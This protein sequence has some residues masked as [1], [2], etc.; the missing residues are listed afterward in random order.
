MGSLEDISPAN[1]KKLI[2]ILCNEG[3]SEIDIL[4]GE[5]TLHPAISNFVE[6][7]YRNN[8]VTSLS[9]NGYDTN[10]LTAWSSRYEKSRVNIGV[11]LYPENRSH[12]LRRYIQACQPV[13]KSVAA[14]GAFV[15][16][17]GAYY[18]RT[19]EL[20]YSVIYMDVLAD[21]D[22]PRSLPF[23][24]FYR[25]LR[26][27]QAIFQ[28]LEGVYCSGFV[29]DVMRNPALGHTRCPA[30]TTKLSVLPDGCVYPCYLLFPYRQFFLGNIFSDDFDTIW[31]NRIL[32]FFRDFRGNQCARRDCT[33]FDD[34]HGGCPAISLSIFGD[35]SRGDPRCT[36]MQK[37]TGSKEER[38]NIL[39]RRAQRDTVVP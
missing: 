6:I 26:A 19:R 14:R 8:I 39:V 4:G 37:D 32:D 7:N 5:P 23:Y 17:F 15:P 18:L 33:L 28:N 21:S 12:A 20:P 31:N 2:S 11:S 1:Y 24:D 36:C 34:C 22:L 13:V 16:D 9:T 27:M 29:P 35:I 10:L 38:E 30:G 25:E 3:I